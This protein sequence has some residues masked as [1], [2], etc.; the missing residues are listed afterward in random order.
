[1]MERNVLLTLATL[2]PENACTP[3]LLALNALH[4][5][6]CAKI[7]SIALLGEPLKISHANALLQF[8][9]L[10][11]VFALL[12]LPWARPVLLANNANKAVHQEMHVTESPP[13]APRTTMEKLYA[14][15]QPFLVMM[16]LS[17]Q[18]IPATLTLEFANTNS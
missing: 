4:L 11:S 9:T 6:H 10:P 5:L 13:L 2:Q 7:I 16:H 15:A 12:L 18:L 1:M 17:A 3:K 14:I 8:V